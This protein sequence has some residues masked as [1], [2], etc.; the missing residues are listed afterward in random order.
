M[1]AAECKT[2]VKARARDHQ[3]LEHNLRLIQQNFTVAEL[4]E[5]LGVSI[6]TWTNRM[7]EPWRRFSYDDLRTIAQY[8]RIDFVKLVDGELKI[9]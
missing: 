8:C 9:G 7:K 1:I 4:S 5:V 3:R 2:M 6:N